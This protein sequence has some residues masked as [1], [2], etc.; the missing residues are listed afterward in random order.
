MSYFRD[1]HFVIG[2]HGCV[3]A[4]KVVD[5]LQVRYLDLLN[6]PASRSL[7]KV[8]VDGAVLPYV[9]A[10]GFRAG[11]DNLDVAIIGSELLCLD[12][13]LCYG[14]PFQARSAITRRASYAELG[15]LVPCPNLVLESVVLRLPY[16][17]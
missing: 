7:R 1:S 11:C 8:L 17:V 14:L 13:H 15:L 2:C 16:L 4:D 12:L 3:L 6:L 9:L 5:P 10:E